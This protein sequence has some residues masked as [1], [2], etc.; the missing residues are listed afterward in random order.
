MLENWFRKLSVQVW[1]TS[2][3]VL[4][5][6]LAALVILTIYSF[7]HPT[8]ARD[9]REQFNRAQNLAS[10]LQYDAD[11]QPV[12]I[13]IPDP[14]G[15][16]AWIFRV[17]PDEVKY[18]VLDERGESL[19]SSNKTDASGP[20]I[21]GD[22]EAALDQL[23]RV[24]IGPTTYNIMTARTQHAGRIF[25]VQIAA[26]DMFNR[27][28]VHQKTQDLPG[29]VRG[30]FIVVMLVFALTLSLTVRR[31]LKPLRKVSDAA[32][33]ITPR[34][35]AQRLPTQSVP[36]EIRPLIHA[37][38]A[39][40]DRI[41]HGYATQQ[42]FLSAA[43]HEL[44]TPLTL[45]R[46]QIE[47]AGDIAGKD[48]LLREID[49]MARQ[50]RQLL[51]LAE[52]SEPESFAFAEINAAAVARD[53]LSYLD[54]KARS[55]QVRLALDAPGDTVPLWADRSALF[56]LLKNIVENAINASPPGGEVNVAVEPDAIR[57]EDDGPGISEADLPMLFQRFR[58]GAGARH[59]G[60]GL[61]LSICREI[62]LAHQW[63]L[64]VAPRTPGT[65][66][67]VWTH[68]PA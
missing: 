60:A 21:P 37:F 10:N 66:F 42:Q 68:K 22:P 65:R 45:L 6:I 14:D 26:S 46:G 61:G 55:S 1:A 40:L 24:T 50:V 56:I 34:N 47:L 5:V 35:L 19:L 25:Y 12:D 57:V 29:V 54:G 67:I 28:I 8:G 64:A 59:P 23:R 52:V 18:R 38:N 63:R 49:F 30:T 27:A 11:G 53:V 51:H 9:S 43:A 4:A 13:R 15:I 16:M 32:A 48:L 20:W 17:I 62:A 39:T 2:V 33:S 41:E 3:A 7:D 31:V 44:Q 36:S 58:R